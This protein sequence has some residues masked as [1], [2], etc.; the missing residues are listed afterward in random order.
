MRCVPSGGTES[1][2]RAGEGRAVPPSAA[3]PTPGRL[4]GARIPN[5]A[6]GLIPP[7]PAEGAALVLYPE[8]WLMLGR[9]P[10]PPRAFTRPQRSLAFP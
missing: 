8:R 9:C 10:G 3:R 5:A 2:R 4:E 7:P 6:R 1:S